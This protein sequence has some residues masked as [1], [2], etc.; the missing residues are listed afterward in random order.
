MMER[1]NI[2]ILYHY[3]AHYRSPIFGLLTDDSSE[4]GYC[5]RVYA[6]GESNDDYL[7]VDNKTQDVAITIKNIWFGKHFLWQRGAVKLAF[8]RDIDTLILLGNMYFISNWVVA[9]LARL[10]GKK[11]LMWTHGVR[12]SS[13][14]RENLRVWFYRLADGLL[15]YGHRAENILASWG[16]NNNSLHV[17][18]NSLDYQQ[19]SR[20]RD[21]LTLADVNAERQRFLGPTKGADTRSDV[22]TRSNG[23]IL[24]TSGRLT[25]EKRIDQLLHAISQLDNPEIKLLVVGDG[26]ELMQLQALCN[27][28]DL[29]RQ[30]FFLGACYEEATLAKLFSAADLCV[31]PG[32]IGLTC[33][34]A[35]SYGVPCITHDNFDSQ[36]PEFEAIVPD[37]TG[38]F[39]TENDINAL[40]KAIDVWVTKQNDDKLTDDESALDN[41]GEKTSWSLAKRTIR[42]ACIAMIEN[43]YTPYIQKKL[44]D[45]AVANIHGKKY[46]H[47]EK[48]KAF[49][50][51]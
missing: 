39:F 6:D 12:R 45:T 27:M 38:S 19:I 7:K 25:K 23:S 1:K 50:A 15:L 48:D 30:V 20:L 21:S 18:Y 24:I 51:G 49:S 14:L 34:H 31:V 36:K 32:N 40:A 26:P 5:Y 3:V 33:I 37:E 13:G 2:A 42:Q 41:L 35:M 17:I 16:L 29:T 47:T 22:D 46:R 9:V 4:D 43:R 28:L 11:V 44:I 10:S 8:A